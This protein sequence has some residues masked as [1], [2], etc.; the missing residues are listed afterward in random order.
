MHIK[1]KQSTKPKVG[2]FKTKERRKDSVYTNNNL[3]EKGDL[4]TDLVV[5]KN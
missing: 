4:S 1:H 3:N 5:I 2:N